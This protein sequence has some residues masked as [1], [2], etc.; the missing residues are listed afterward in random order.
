MSASNPPE[1]AGRK[2][3]MRQEGWPVF[4]GSNNPPSLGLRKAYSL[5]RFPGK[6]MDRERSGAAKPRSW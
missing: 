3:S 5:E 2:A 1:R 4:G 6:L